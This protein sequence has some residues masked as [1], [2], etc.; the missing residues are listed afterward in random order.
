MRPSPNPKV[1]EALHAADAIIYS[2]GSLY[3][4]LIPS[5]I[6]PGVGAA[7]ARPEGPR[8]KILLLNGSLD[9]ETGG[10]AA[11]DF[12]DAITAACTESHSHSHST[13][14][15]ASHPSFDSGGCNRH[16]WTRYIT[17]V[18]HLEGEG[19][20]GVDKAELAAR[21]VECV[22]LYGRRGDDG[23]GRYDGKALAQALGAILGRRGGGRSRRNTFEG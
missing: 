8:S 14:A 16:D 1:L 9:R 15:A 22:R 7:I 10:F 18:I 2:I 13:S 11:A 23:V 20:P 21:G 17:H 4:S 3:T 19:A 5:L 6:L 12:L